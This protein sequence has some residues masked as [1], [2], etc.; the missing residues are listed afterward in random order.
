MFLGC[1]CID[2]HFVETVETKNKNK[3]KKT[4][5]KRF[6]E[7]FRTV[8]VFFVFVMKTTAQKFEQNQ[9]HDIIR[10]SEMS[11]LFNK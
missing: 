1:N 10:S 7:I 4:K 6:V 11:M 9:C 8:T 5:K 2:K 3:K